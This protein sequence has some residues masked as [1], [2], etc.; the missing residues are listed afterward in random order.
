M[1]QE[2]REFWSATRST[3]DQTRQFQHQIRAVEDKR[4]RQA[5]PE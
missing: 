3:T 5:K 1:E 2:F 4:R